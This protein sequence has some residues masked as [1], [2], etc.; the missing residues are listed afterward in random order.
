M[1]AS[2]F[3]Y[4]SPKMFDIYRFYDIVPCVITRIMNKFLKYTVLCFG[5]IM[6]TTSLTSCPGARA[7][8][9]A[10]STTGRS[11]G[12]Y[13][14]SLR[15]AAQKTCDVGSNFYNLNDDNQRRNRNYSNYSNYNNYSYGNSYGGNRYGGYGS[16]GY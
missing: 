13:G 10:A 12:N 8:S 14:R 15:S 6:C 5:A 16:Y 9:K 3:C 2:F 4:I 7:A 1:C 11:A